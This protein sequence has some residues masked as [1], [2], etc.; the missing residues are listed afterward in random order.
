M[1]LS[2]FGRKFSGDTGV[3]L[4]MDDL[5]Q[6]LSGDHEVM[7]LGGG[8]PAYI[9]EMQ[10]QLRQQMI[11]LLLDEGRFERTIGDYSP[12]QGNAAFIAALAGLLQRTYGWDIGPENIA[13]TNGSQTAF[14]YLFN[15]FGGQYP[16]GSFKKILLPLAPEYIGYVDTGITPD[17]FV[18]SKP[19]I[20]YLDDCLFK[21]HVDFEHLIV[22]D[23]IAAICVSRPTNPTGNVLTDE[24]VAHLSQIAKARGIPFII[25]NAYGEPFPGI[26]FSDVEPIWDEH[27][28]LS[29]SLSKLGLPGVRTGIV[30][31][32]PEVIKAISAM[33][34]VV[35]LSP[36]G[37]GAALTTD[38][39][40]SGKVLDLGREIIRPFYERKAWLAVEWL[41]RE[42]G[43]ATCYI[44]K[45]EGAF[46]LW[47][48]FRD[49][50]ITS[51][52][53]YQRL[54]ARGVIVVPGEFFFPGL[55]HEAW[56]HKHECIRMSYAQDA[57]VVEQGIRIIAEEVKRAY[58]IVR[59]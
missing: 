44:H 38:M 12:P 1:Q 2:N 5:G 33:N 50:P 26:I 39:V 59:E 34:A 27:V 58:G 32:R 51:A 21:Y 54:K 35:S 40:R 30:L 15:M 9:P 18:A 43:D 7:M 6:A 29:M 4:L 22:G 53:L 42:M 13:L 37:F 19:G 45:P 11:D 56:P 24:E 17:L 31:A 23:D 16:D 47:L 25:D 8:N 14:F 28:I 46:F 41:H 10:S 55:E 20:E 52:E 49:L 57:S 36:G 3:T 48:W